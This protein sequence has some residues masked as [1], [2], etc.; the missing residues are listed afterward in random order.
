MRC[1]S[2]SVLVVVLSVAAGI[3][4]V[5]SGWAD[6]SATGTESAPVRWLLKTTRGHAVARQASEIRVP[7]LSAPALAAYGASAFDQMCAGCH[8]A[9]GRKP[10]LGAGY[11]NPKPPDLADVAGQRTAAELFWVIKH[12]IRMTGMPAW[13][14]THSNDQLWALVA[15]VERLPDLSEE[16][17]RQLVQQAGDQDHAHQHA[18]GTSADE[19]GTQGHDHN[20][21]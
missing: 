6:I 20:G 9:P 7:D 21:H 5:Y 1:L 3:G 17:F 16:A 14:P 15:L 13:G 18:H 11:M 19:P 12:G 2:A 8:G 10:M 4:F